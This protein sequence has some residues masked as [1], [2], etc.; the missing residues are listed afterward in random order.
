VL[1]NYFFPNGKYLIEWIG[2][3]RDHSFGPQIGTFTLLD[4]LSFRFLVVS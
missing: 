1:S 4:Y 3:S 2:I